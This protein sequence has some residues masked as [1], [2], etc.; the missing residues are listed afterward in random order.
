MFPDDRPFLALKWKT[1]NLSGCFAIGIDI[2]FSRKE[3]S[4]KSTDELYGENTLP[5]SDTVESLNGGVNLYLSEGENIEEEEMPENIWYSLLEYLKTM[6]IVSFEGCT[7]ENCA[8]AYMLDDNN[9]EIC[10]CKVTLYEN[11][12]VVG[13]CPIEFPEFTIGIENEKTK[14]NFEFVDKD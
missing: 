10:M 11:G 9:E 1:I 13:H 3:L 5:M 12:E 6:K 7:Y 8:A 2:F 4:L 14:D